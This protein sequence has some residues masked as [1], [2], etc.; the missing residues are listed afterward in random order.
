MQQSKP[1]R[2]PTPASWKPGQSGNP[3]GSPK[4]DESL[5]GL[6][7]EFL[8]GIDE[9]TGK[10]RRQMFIEKAFKKAEEEGDNVTMKLIWNYLDGLP[11]AKLDL[12]TKGEKINSLKE[13]TDAELQ[14]IAEGS[15]SRDG[16]EGTSEETSD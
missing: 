2:A 14:A 15:A 11:Q 9:K 5:T 1:T 13:L 4:R 6:M 10:E 3:K 16:E 7:R 8:K 12:T